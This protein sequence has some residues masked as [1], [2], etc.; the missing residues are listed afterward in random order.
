MVNDISVSAR[1]L[2]VC[3]CSTSG[4]G[5]SV[6]SDVR[7]QT[8]PHTQVMPVQ[9]LLRSCWSAKKFQAGSN[10]PGVSQ[11]SRPF[12]LPDTGSMKATVTTIDSLM[13]SQY[14]WSCVAMIGLLAKEAD[15][16]GRWSEG[17]PCHD[18]NKLEDQAKSCAYRGCRAPEL[19]Q[20]SA[21]KL[22]ENTMKSD[23]YLFLDCLHAAPAAKKSELLSSWRTS[24][25][26]MVGCL[27]ALVALVLG[28]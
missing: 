7:A 11:P 26:K 2:P 14:D 1:V 28:L 24:R 18:G 12:L 10:A 13:A 22:M 6:G 5:G 21:G 17:C 16:V 23:A 15:L 25:S 19:A 9:Q 8:V 3:V 20:G 4:Q 27:D